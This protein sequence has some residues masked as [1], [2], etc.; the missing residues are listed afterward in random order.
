MTATTSTFFV[1]SFQGDTVRIRLAEPRFDKMI[2]SAV[3]NVR[4]TTPQNVREFTERL[5]EKFTGAVVVP[6]RDETPKIHLLVE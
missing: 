5:L 3:S 2:K 6:E 1:T 4:S